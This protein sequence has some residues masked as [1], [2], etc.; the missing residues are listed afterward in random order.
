[1]E[2]FNIDIKS[3][4]EKDISRIDSQFI[5]QILNAI[6]K[7]SINPFHT[8]SKKL[9]GSKSSYRLRSGDYRIIYKIDKMS[10]TVTIFHIKHRKESYKKR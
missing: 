1:M 7:L 10:K 6:E 4:V 9:K 2:R 8:S 5:P 3:S